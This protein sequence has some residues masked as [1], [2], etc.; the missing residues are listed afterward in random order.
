MGDSLTKYPNRERPDDDIT[1]AKATELT[2]AATTTQRAVATAEE[3]F[4]AANDA[5][6][7]AKAD[8]LKLIGE[9]IGNLDMKLSPSDPRWLAFG[10]QLPSTP[11]TPAAPTGLRATIM[12]TKVLLECDA[13]DLATRYRFR[14]KIIG[15]DPQYRLLASA[16]VPMAALEG[17][18]PG[19]MI[20]IVAQAVN[21]PSQSVPSGAILVTIPATA[22][23]TSAAKPVVSDAELAPLAAIV[24]NGSSNGN[25][26]GNGS[27]AVA[28][29]LS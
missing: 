17:L 16:P 19:L 28:S 25:G 1:A 11:T 26:N 27:H 9:V 22:E 12:D 15:V 24:P 8:L 18:A 7:P 6:K 3:A 4:K 2:V 21:G 14:G 20:E 23:A 29:R 5:R 10:C 13:M